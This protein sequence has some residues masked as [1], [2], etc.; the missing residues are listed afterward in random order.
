MKRQTCNN[1]LTVSALKKKRGRPK[2][3]RFNA[4]SSSGRNLLLRAL[5]AACFYS[6][7]ALATELPQPFVHP[8][9]AAMG[10][11]FTAVANDDSAIWTNPAGIGRIKKARTRGTF[12]LLRAP[13]IIVGSNNISNYS[14]LASLQGRHLFSAQGWDEDVEGQYVQ[15][16]SLSSGM[17]SI[18]E[19]DENLIEIFKA[20]PEANVWGRFDFGFLSIFEFGRGATP[21]ALGMYFTSQGNLAINDASVSSADDID[22]NTIVK[23]SDVIN[24][25]PVVGTAYS[26]K[27]KRFNIGV[28]VRPMVRYSYEASNPISFYGDEEAFTEEIKENSNSDSAVAYDFGLLWTLA[29]FWYPTFGLAIF[30]LPSSCKEDYLNPYDQTRHTVCG[31]NFESD[32][33]KDKNSLANLDP[34]DIR[35]GI[36]ITPR[37]SRKVAFRLA[38]DYHYITVNQDGT[39][40][41]LPEIPPAL[42]SHVGL[43]FFIGNPLEI[44][45]FRAKFGLNQGQLTVG[46]SI[47]L[48]FMQ[49]DLASYGLDLSTDQTPK[50]D[51]RTILSVSA[52]F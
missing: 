14:E 5:F 1:R 48:G 27:T 49:I 41:G 2:V 12:Q 47:D 34:T 35:A 25:I 52:G 15:M 10:G 20:N 31:T 21:L 17:P 26:N 38:F 29:D 46:G 8:S 24:I 37:M 22:Q 39:Y 28:Q 7:P 45:P 23:F 13:Q 33:T 3:E 44:S 4:N 50:A 36:S 32:S 18:E 51:R 42:Q 11:A 43:E 9:P 19:L 16:D 40:Y 30:N 6:F